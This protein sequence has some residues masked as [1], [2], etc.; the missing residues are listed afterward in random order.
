MKGE[1]LKAKPAIREFFAAYARAWAKGGSLDGRGLVPLG[2]ADAEAANKQ[3]VELKP[4]D[5]ATL[6]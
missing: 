2:G 5:P 3:A 4:L 1:H 6:K